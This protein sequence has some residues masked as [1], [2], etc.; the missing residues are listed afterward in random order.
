MDAQTTTLV[1]R[2]LLQ[3][4]DI[5][6][7]RNPMWL[8][9]AICAA[10]AFWAKD[11]KAV[12]SHAGIIVDPAGTTFEAQWTVCKR[13]VWTEFEG[14]R[15]L[16]ARHKQMIPA[17]FEEAFAKIAHYEGGWYPIHRLPMHLFP[18]LARLSVGFAVCS[19]LTAEFLFYAG[20]MEY[21]KG[22]NPDD[23]HDLVRHWQD[24]SVVI[25]R[26]RD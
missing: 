20:L 19:E 10:E 21:W 9:R 22:V 2:P 18:P 24:W 15:L 16:I 17:L 26:N 3:A 13:N 1:E 11:G 12:Y 6:L 25:E 7:T 8:G 23:L 5:F 4:G 14:D